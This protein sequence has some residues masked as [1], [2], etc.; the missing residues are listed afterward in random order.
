M[1]RDGSLLRRLSLGSL[2][3]IAFVLSGINGH[4]HW[5]TLPISVPDPLQP[6]PLISQ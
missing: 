6:F 2:A 1:S 4:F 3:R 5:A